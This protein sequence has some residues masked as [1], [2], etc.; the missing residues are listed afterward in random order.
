MLLMKCAAP[1]LLFEA[2]NTT[3]SKNMKICWIARRKMKIVKQR[4]QNQKQNFLS[5]KQ[6]QK[7]NKFFVSLFNN[8][9]RSEN[10]AKLL[11]HVCFCY[12]WRIINLPIQFFVSNST[13]IAYKKNLYQSIFSWDKLNCELRGETL[14]VNKWFFLPICHSFVVC[15]NHLK[16]FSFLRQAAKIS[17]GRRRESKL[18]LRVRGFQDL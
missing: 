15:S 6:T 3:F 9:A 7:L 5:R 8:R 17:K 4:K 18:Q 10:K 11:S 12:K 16:S 2:E 14:L 1:L 13:R